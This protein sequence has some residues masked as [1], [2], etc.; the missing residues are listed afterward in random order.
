MIVQ[1]KDTNQ[2]ESEEP[3]YFG[4]LPVDPD[5]VRLV[6]GVTLAVLCLL[7]VLLKPP[8]SLLI[9]ASS[10]ERPHRLIT[11]HTV[12]DLVEQ[13]QGNDLWDVE[14]HSLVPPVLIANFPSD[15]NS[16]DFRLKKKVF[17][18][19]LLPLAMVAMAEVEDE[20]TALDATLAKLSPL[21]ETLTFHIGNAPWQQGLTRNEVSFLRF[22]T[23]KYRTNAVDELLRRVNV[24]PVSLLMAQGAIESSWGGSRFVREANNLFGIWTWSGN[25]IIPNRREEGKKHRVAIYES[26]LDSVRA[27]I[28]MINRVRAYRDLR[29]IRTTSMDSIQLTQGLLYYSERRH[30]YIND[31]ADV[32]VKNGLRKYDQC[33]LSSSHRARGGV[34]MINVASLQ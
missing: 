2:T 21:P 7:I 12:E 26:L 19:S 4:I 28:L 14:G 24:I 20:R 17:L 29:K 23:Q 22:L 8:V 32:I 30:A 13:L 9:N 31:V 11:I 15:I 27:Y 34:R 33:V 16:L 25:G 5:L 18:H 1:K 3:I 10:I 6:A